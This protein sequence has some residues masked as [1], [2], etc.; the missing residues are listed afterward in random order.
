VLSN[1]KSKRSVDK[2]SISANITRAAAI[3][4][5]WGANGDRPAAM[6]SAFDTGDALRLVDGGEP[7]I[8]EGH[9]AEVLVFDLPPVSTGSLS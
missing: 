3:A 7:R 8:D 4:A 9:G 6:R 2:R 5:C 1:A